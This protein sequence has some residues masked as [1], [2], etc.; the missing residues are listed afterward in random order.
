MYLLEFLGNLSKIVL[1]WGILGQFYGIYG[2]FEE[3]SV[4][5]GVFL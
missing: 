3:I 2:V 5:F 4:F 1:F